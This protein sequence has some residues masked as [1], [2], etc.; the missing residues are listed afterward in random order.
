[1]H[2]Y[3]RLPIAICLV[4]VHADEDVADN[5]DIIA[6]EDHRHLVDHEQ[7]DTFESGRA[8]ISAHYFGYLRHLL[9]DCV[10]D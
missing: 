10:E 4:R 7:L 1:M 3:V 5:V 9:V 6:E 2:L 8:N